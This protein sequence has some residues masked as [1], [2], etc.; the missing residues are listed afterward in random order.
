[1]LLFRSEEHVSRWSEMRGIARGASLTLPQGWDL[2]RIWYEDRLSPEW[3]RR[4][5][6]EAEAVFESLG[7]T[8]AFWKLV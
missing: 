1:M 2:A 3:H 5:P 8:G 6:E 4:T 7:L